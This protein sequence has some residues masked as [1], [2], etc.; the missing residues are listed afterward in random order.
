MNLCEALRVCR[1]LSPSVAV[2]LPALRALCEALVSGHDGDLALVAHSC[3]GAAGP[4]DILAH[5]GAVSAIPDLCLVARED[6]L[7]DLIGAALLQGRPV[8]CRRTRT[9]PAH[10]RWAERAWRL[11]FSTACAAPFDAGPG[12]SGA[13]AVFSPGAHTFDADEL[14]LLVDIAAA[15]R[16][17]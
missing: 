14:D 4:L 15:L 7:V 3:A 6:P 11:G 8:V 13:V 2:P 10:A 9:D 16:R 12:R 1:E 5:A 17:A